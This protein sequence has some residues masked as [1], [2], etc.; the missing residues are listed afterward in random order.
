M[1]KLVLLVLFSFSIALNALTLEQALKNAKPLSYDVI[2]QQQRIAQSQLDGKSIEQQLNYQFSLD[3]QLGLR[4]QFG[5]QEDDSFAYFNLKKPLFDSQYEIDLDFNK[6]NT[7]VEKIRLD[8][9]KLE[10]KVQIMR[11]FFAGV[12]ADLEY[13]YFTQILALSAVRQGNIKESFSIGFASEV[14][15]EQSRAKTNL[16]FA[17]RQ[18][19]ESK[20]ILSRKQLADLLGLAERP[21]ELDYPALKKYLNY[22][23]EDQTAWL[24][25][26][27]Q[28]NSLLHILRLEIANLERKKQQQQ[29]AWDFSI[30]GFARLGEQTYNKDKNGNYRAGLIFSVPFGDDARQQ[31]IKTLDILIQQKQTELEQQ[32]QSLAQTVLD[33]FLKFQSASQQYKALKIQQDYLLFNLD[34]AS[35]EY[36][37]RLSRNIG[38]AMVKV[39]KNDFDLAQSKFKIALLLEQINLLTQGQLL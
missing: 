1:I 27:K 5:L 23:V 7:T 16:D 19:I 6:S 38:N 34:K 12:L 25:S 11:V 28:H 26:L 2:A 29:Q 37:M 10:Q 39:T 14:E 15:L 33:L 21:D 17:A 18:Q 22:T 3:T 9:L 4:E 8:Y 36:E 13:D 24:K 35:L 31:N 32:N 20:Q 30:E